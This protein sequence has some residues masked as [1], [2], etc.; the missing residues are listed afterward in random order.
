MGFKNAES[1]LALKEEISA[2]IDAGDLS[3]ALL[4]IKEFVES[5]ITEPICTAQVY[6][7]ASLDALCQRIG[8]VSLSRVLAQGTNRSTV[9][10]AR[11]RAVF[12][13]TKLQKS[14]GH[15]RVILDFIRALPEFDHVILSTELDGKSE[16]ISLNDGGQG[17]GQVTF[18]SAPLPD[19]DDRLEWL[20]RRLLELA[21][22]RIYVFNHH[23]DSVA[24][25]ALQPGI[26]AQTYFYHHA[27]HHFCLGIYV[28][29]F[30]HIDPHP[31]GYQNCR[32]VLGIDNIF[33]PLTVQDKGDRAPTSGFL[34]NGV[35]TTCTAGRSNKLEVPYYVR[36]TDVVPALLVATKGK[37]V[38]IGRLT[39]WA[40]FKIRRGL[41][42][43]RI[44]AANFIYLPWVPSVWEALHRFQIDLYI[45]S[46]PYGGGLTLI[47]AM[48]SGTPVAVHQHTYSR[49]LSGRDLAYEGAFSW[50]TPA[51][52]L[53]YCTSLSRS[54]LDDAGRQSRRQFE[55]FYSESQLSLFLHRSPDVP[56]VPPYSTR[57]FPVDS[58]EWA[59]SVQRQVGFGRLVSRA[60]FRSFKR[61]RAWWQAHTA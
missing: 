54:A 41:R 40:L 16:L 21:P 48:G 29:H 45:A 4:S 42:K 37:H 57:P 17:T 58:D 6:G 1:S 2:Q 19:Y 10:S 13:V 36:Y 56:Q 46:F 43:M 24:V 20:Q 9:K 15:T 49:I 38:H 39:P 22:K 30:Q 11:P 5:I 26:G 47:E 51:Q 32:D 34:Q 33:I 44:P 60:A 7:S 25:S 50:R 35:L 59:F 55:A 28:R 3:H 18:D 27:D 14:G 8:A 52:L 31:M 61:L 23:Q 12:V 53:A